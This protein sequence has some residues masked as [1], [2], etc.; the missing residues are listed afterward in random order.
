[1][2]VSPPRLRHLLPL[3]AALYIAVYFCWFSRLSLLA[4]ITQDDLMNIHAALVRSYHALLLDNVVF[5]RFTPVHRPLGALVYKGFFDL[6][7]FNLL[8]LR[9]FILALIGAN[10]VLLYL[11]ARRLT[12]SREAGFLAALICAYHGRFSDFYYNSGTLYDVL[13]E[14]FYFSALVYYLRIRQEGRR[15]TV[16]QVL[17]FAVLYALALDSKE[18]AVTLPAVIVTYELLFQRSLRGGVAAFIAAAM[19]AVFCWGRMTGPGSLSQV[20]GYKITVSLGEYLTKAGLCLDGLFYTQ[21]WFDNGRTLLVLAGLLAL[22][23]VLRSKPLAFCWALFALGMLP[24]AFIQ[25]RALYAASIPV[26]GL[27]IYVAAVL[28]LGRDW[29]IQRRGG[30]ACQVALF[31]VVALLLLRAHRV[32]QPERYLAAWQAEYGPIRSVRGQLHQLHPRMPQSGRVLVVNDP[33]G[34][35]DW[36]SLFVGRLLYHDTTL[37]VDSLSKLNPKPEGPAIEAY[38]V[39]LT[40]ENGTLRDVSPDQVQSIIR[41]AAPQSVPAGQL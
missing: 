25:P 30:V 21:G 35:F 19:A 26:A 7:G 27:A 32:Q 28:V 41:T 18:M 1:M 2:R 4:E 15:L 3:A 23:A 5:F 29:L 37:T 10:L 13:C 12:A 22:A 8:P 36:A 33:F 9:S 14:F 17:T 11:V 20:S 6:F 40:Y 34:R 24:I 31:V 38:D 16:L 39:I